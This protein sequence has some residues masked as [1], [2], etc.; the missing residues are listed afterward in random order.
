MQKASMSLAARV[1]PWLRVCVLDHHHALCKTDNLAL[2][3]NSYCRHKTLIKVNVKNSWRCFIQLY[4]ILVY[5]QSHLEAHTENIHRLLEKQET[6]LN[7]TL[8]QQHW[9]GALLHGQDQLH[10]GVL[11]FSPFSLSFS[12][13][14]S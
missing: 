7:R 2:K 5:Q 13:V 6:D 1:R 9:L 3:Y 8:V 11:V 12:S 14:V 10:Y 4:A